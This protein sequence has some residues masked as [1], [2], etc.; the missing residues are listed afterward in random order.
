MGDKFKV[1]DIEADSKDDVVSFINQ[2]GIDIST[3]LNT[4]KKIVVPFWAIIVASFLILVNAC[5][6]LWVD[7]IQ[8]RGVCT[9]TLVALCFLNISLIYMCWK[10]KILTGIIA[11]GELVVFV[12]ALNIYTPKDVIDKIEHHITNNEASK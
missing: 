5:A 3:Y 4:P 6:L 8:W 7:S 1:K 10:N 12:L 9:I 2:T 11:L